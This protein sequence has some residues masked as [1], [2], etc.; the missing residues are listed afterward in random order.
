MGQSDHPAAAGQEHV[1]FTTHP[2]GPD[3]PISL[4][5]H[6][7]GAVEACFEAQMELASTPERMAAW[8]DRVWLVLPADYRSESPR[9]EVFTVR[10]ELEPAMGR[11]HPV[12]RDRLEVV[13]PLPGLGTLAGFLGTVD[14]P[15]ALIWP[16]R[17]TGSDRWDRG[18]P[19]A[20]HPT[21]EQPRLM[22]LH[23]D[24][25]RDIELPAGFE[26]GRLGRLVTGGSDGRALRLLTD[27]AG[28]AAL[29][30]VYLRDAE[31]ATWTTY[32][33]P[34]DMQ[35]VRSTHLVG[36]R[37]VLLLDSVEEAGGL[38]LAYLR[39]TGLLPLAQLEA[40]TGFWAVLGLRDGLR[41]LEWSETDAEAFTIRRIDPVTGQIGPRQDLGRP[42]APAGSVFQIAI[43][44]AGLI[45][46]L[47]LVFVARPAV[48][49]AH[50]LAAGLVPLPVSSRLA[51]LAVD[52]APGGLLAVLITDS[53]PAALL[54]W[55][56]WTAG[57]SDGIPFLIMAAI[58]VCHVTIVELT[59]GTTLG[60]SLM[61]GKVL[62][63]DGS[64]ARPWPVLLRNLVK[65]LI[66]VVPPLGLFALLNPNLQGV[67]DLVSHTVVVR[68]QAEETADS[69]SGDDE[70][71]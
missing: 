35:R 8:G 31:D 26:S 3:E 58:T 22:Q 10:T 70:G 32:R 24:R 34:L 66:V 2:A 69:S 4:C 13:E 16:A 28:D 38:E 40:P 18:E 27:S 7:A 65:C 42:T 44:M 29:T 55:P 52:A 68:S 19:T 67:G 51:A 37:P 53:A 14:G 63:A 5:H 17:E 64:R 15:V 48:R 39:P 20:I 45:V 60:K 57:L 6:A 43:L 49:R 56:L 1:W 71:R 21:L 9:R 62:S 61:G 50:P 41:L 25:W 11:Y 12:P 54:K 30:A 36:D 47:A 33:I 59:K 23:G 46:A